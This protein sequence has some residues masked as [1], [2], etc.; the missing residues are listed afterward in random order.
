MQATKARVTAALNHNTWLEATDNSGAKMCKI[1][2]ILGSRGRTVKGRQPAAGVGDL[3]RIVV[4]SGKADV[5]KQV[6]DAVI[7]R[8]K[9]EYRRPDGTRVSFED[10]AV[11]LLKDEFGNPKGTLIK[12]PIARE[13][14]EKWP[15]LSKIAMQIV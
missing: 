14:A 4:K 13:V 9:M 2:A 7:V 3:I 5:R 15:S 10:N 8:Q 6:I 12:G 1:V 11:A